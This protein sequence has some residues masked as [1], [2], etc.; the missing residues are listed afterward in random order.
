MFDSHIHSKFS[1]DSHMEAA[2][3]CERAFET[4]LAGIIFTD[5]V[6]YDYPE[7]DDNLL[8]DFN[9]YF[10]FFGALKEQWKG[11]LEVLAGVEMGFQPHVLD[12]IKETLSKYPFD[13]ILNSVHI[14]D[15]MDPYYGAFFEGRTQRESYERYLQEILVSVDAYDDYDII[16]HIGYAARYGKFEDKRLRYA[17]YSDILD[18]ILKAVIAK[19][20]GIEMNTSGLR[21]DL[22]SSI[23]GYDVFKRY[24]EL[25]GETVTVGSDAHFREHLGHSFPEALENLRNIGFKYVAH[26]EKRKP[27]FDKL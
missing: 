21:S 7:F 22:K 4:G 27:V 3:A 2:E 9:K 24:F 19:G 5:H 20:K 18:E 23:P 6:D 12:L 25:G 13:F 11:K 8:I 1:T 17:D 14:I 16:G 10:E 26:F 15:H